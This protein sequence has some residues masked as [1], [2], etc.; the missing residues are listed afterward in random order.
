MSLAAGT[1]G[2]TPRKRRSSFRN[3][4]SRPAASLGSSAKYGVLWRRRDARCRFFILFSGI[5]W[6]TCVKYGVFLRRCDAW[7]RFSSVVSNIIPRFTCAIFGAFWL[8][9]DDRRRDACRRI[10]MSSSL[11][12]RRSFVPNI[13]CAGVVS[14]GVATLRVVSTTSC[15]VTSWG[16]LA[17]NITNSVEQSPSWEAKTRLS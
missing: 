7:R 14:I 11:I 2:V 4:V 12:S 6:M 1:K 15:S 13:F 5:P 17:Q 3:H 10:S 9:R 16:S 8:R